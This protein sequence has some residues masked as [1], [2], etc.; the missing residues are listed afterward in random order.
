MRFEIKLEMC[1]FFSQE[2]QKKMRSYLDE[3]TTITHI[4]A[5]LK[6]CAVLGKAFVFFSVSLVISR[7][8]D[9]LQ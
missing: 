5:K 4:E 8:D 2:L 6:V 9:C 7:S 1:L 3:Q